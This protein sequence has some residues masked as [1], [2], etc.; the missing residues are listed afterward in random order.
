[1]FIIHTANLYL[2]RPFSTFSNPHFGRIKRQRQRDVLSEIVNKVIENN[3]DALLIAGNLLEA[4]YITDDTLKWVLKTFESISP[5]PVI[6]APGNADALSKYSPYFLEPL[7]ENVIVL[8]QPNWIKWE[9]KSIPLVVHGFAVSDTDFQGEPYPDLETID[10]EKNHIILAY[11][12]PLL[13]KNDAVHDKEIGTY[14]DFGISYIALGKDHKYGQYYHS[15]KCSVYYC[16]LPEPL[17]LEDIPPFGVLG[18]QF[19]CSNNIWETSKIEHIETQKTHYSHIT[20]NGFNMQKEDVLQL[21]SDEIAKIPNPRVCH[22]SFDE[23]ISL[24]LAQSIPDII[25]NLARECELITWDITA[26]FEEIM[27]SEDEEYNTILSEY[28]KVLQEEL[29]SAPDLETQQII[30][31]ARQLTTTAINNQDLMVPCIQTREVP[32]K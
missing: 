19:R 18:V 8:N 30:K 32:F 21:L 6:I 17:C 20:F 14:I 24:K 23:L 29:K 9:S 31:R 11:D 7:P 1:M 13:S 15:S 26:D 5:I 3:A 27:N 22:I 16:G 25:E 4:K 28:Y 10:K 2:D 12:L